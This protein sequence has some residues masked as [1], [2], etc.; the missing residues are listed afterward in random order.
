MVKSETPQAVICRIFG[1][2]CGQA[3]RVSHCESG[4]HTGAQKAVVG[5]AKVLGDPGDDP[6]EPGEGWAAVE[7]GPVKLLA[8]PVTLARLRATAGTKDMQFVRQGRLSVGA[9]TN[10]ELAAV[11]EL[12]KTKL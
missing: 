5:I 12:S 10:E 8:V 6:T 3:L 4:F 2:R 1:S 11:L 9:V 7:L